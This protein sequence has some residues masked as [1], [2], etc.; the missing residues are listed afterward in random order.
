M[1]C[2]N[3]GENYRR[4]GESCC[5]FFEPCWRRQQ[6][7]TSLIKFGISVVCTKS[8]LAKWILVR[9]SLTYKPILY[10]KLKS[11]FI[12]F[13]KETSSCKKLVR[14]IKYRSLQAL[15]LLFEACF[16]MCKYM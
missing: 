13:P 2:R 3:G 14:G 10:M 16:N 6:V 1:P 11:Y 4:F 7:P 12:H 15:Q 5:S 8:F 9:A